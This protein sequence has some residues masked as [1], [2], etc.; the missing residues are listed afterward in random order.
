MQEKP[1]LQD[2]RIIAQL[3]QA[4]GLQFAQVEFLP[5]GADT[6]TAVYRVVTKESV[7]YFLKLR[8]DNFEE[9]SLDVP[10]FLHEQG[11][12][13]V[14]PP[15]NTK[16]GQLWTSLEAYTCILYPFI[17]G[18]DGFEA[19]LSDE[20]W[21][22]FGEALKG[23]HTVILPP[24]LQARIPCETYTPHWREMVKGFQAQVEHTTYA[25]PVAAKMAAFMQA[26]R[27]EIRFLI[28][29]AEQLASTLQ[30]QPL[31]RVLCHADIHAGNL[32]LASDGSLYIVDWDNPILALK[33][34]DLMFIAG[35]VG[36]IWNSVREE[37]LF[38]QGYGSR[39]TNLTALTYYRYERI[40]QDIAAFCE[41][42]LLTGEGGADREQ[43]LR[44]FTSQFLPGDVLEIA[45]QTDRKLKRAKL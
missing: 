15:R 22:D 24:A 14:I 20:Q 5:L 3:W 13:Q 33:E 36:G 2:K 38:Y 10:H 4:Y 6:N 7:P 1:R 39:D 29:R 16:D 30:S 31:E 37:A 28:E 21:V 11:I 42:I 35:G 12:R 27:D 8:K 19:A 45:Y 17:A 34:R 40:I 44:Y 41:Q 23:I 26:H 32:L 18:R 43:G 9:T 25:D